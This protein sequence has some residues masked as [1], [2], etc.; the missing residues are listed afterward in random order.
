VSVARGAKTGRTQPWSR[1]Q[2]QMLALPTPV[3]CAICA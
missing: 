2:R 3:F 1:V